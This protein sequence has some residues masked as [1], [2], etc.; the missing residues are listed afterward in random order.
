MDI[1]YEDGNKAY[2]PIAVEKASVFKLPQNIWNKNSTLLKHTVLIRTS[3]EAKT[4][5]HA[6]AFWQ[7]TNQFHAKN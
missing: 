1:C 5:P 2:F 4:V 3:W 7:F 6:E